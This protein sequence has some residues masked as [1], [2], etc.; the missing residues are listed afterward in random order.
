MGGEGGE[1]MVE[2]VRGIECTEA[3]EKRT[4]SSVC[5]VGVTWLPA[6]RAER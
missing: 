2:G 1:C 3:G 4:L 5:G 6:R